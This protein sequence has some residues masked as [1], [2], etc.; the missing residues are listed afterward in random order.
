MQLTTKTEYAIRAMIELGIEYGNKPLAIREICERQ[1]LPAKYIEQIFRKLRKSN[2]IKSIKGSLGG[3]MLSS[4][5]ENIS[6]K[7]IM[8]A[9]EDSFVSANCSGKE[10]SREFC[11]GEPC[12]FYKAWEKITSDLDSYFSRIRLS[13]FLTHKSG[14]IY[15]FGK[16]A[17]EADN[18]SLTR[19][20]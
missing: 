11:V 14:L 2:L 7:D 12:N 3:Y 4:E 5:P 19:S 1:K 17:P 16:P 18:D 9:V 10:G 6:L 13:T 15:Y 8:I 20:N